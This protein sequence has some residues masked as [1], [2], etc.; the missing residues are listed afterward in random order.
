[1]DTIPDLLSNEHILNF[2]AGVQSL[3][4]WLGDD[5]KVILGAG[6][7]DQGD[8]LNLERFSMFDVFFCEPWDNHGS[9]RKNINYLIKNFYHEKVICFVDISQPAQV[10]Q[11]CRLFQNRFRLIDGFGGHTPHL[12]FDCIVQVL[13]SGG[14]AVNLY[15]HPDG[16]LQDE[17]LYTICVKPTADLRERDANFL[18]A[19]LDLYQIDNKNLENDILFGYLYH[20]QKHV[21]TI[22]KRSPIQVDWPIFTDLN[23]KDKLREMCWL[24]GVLILYSDIPA[25]LQ[26]R[27]EKSTRIWR[28]ENAYPELVITKVAEGGR[29]KRR[30]TRRKRKHSRKSRR[31]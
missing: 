6:D 22:V 29:R 9:L 31:Y 15:E 20:I 24:L 28:P 5:L 3:P 18:L 14:K 7:L 25:G 12:A 23:T 27:Y 17:M 30:Q 8:T 16:A 2:H 13:K 1:M 11:F 26:A 4:D 10:E 19:H 21:L